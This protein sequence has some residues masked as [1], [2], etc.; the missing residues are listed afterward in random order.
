MKHMC[1]VMRKFGL[2]KL[3]QGRKEGRKEGIAEGRA[4]ERADTIFFLIK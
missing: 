3:Q 4:K 1:S 2:Q